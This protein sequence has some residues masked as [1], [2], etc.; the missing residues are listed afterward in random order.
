MATTRLHTHTRGNAYEVIDIPSCQSHISQL[1]IDI[2][3]A[4]EVWCTYC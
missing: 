3:L 2:I 4:Y 1:S